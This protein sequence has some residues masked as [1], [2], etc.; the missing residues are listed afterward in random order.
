[1]KYDV[2][3]TYVILK[4]NP[5]SFRGR[6]FL[7]SLDECKV[8]LVLSTSIVNYS[9]EGIGDDTLFVIMIRT[10]VYS[11]SLNSFQRVNN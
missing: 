3:K 7:L 11:N 8:T 6:T 9:W 4:T 1:M 10:K 2:I 5:W